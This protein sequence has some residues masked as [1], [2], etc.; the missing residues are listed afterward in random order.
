[1]YLSTLTPVAGAFFSRKGGAGLSIF[2][3]QKELLFVR[4][5]SRIPH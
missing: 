1:M 4:Q 3:L 5:Y 2:V